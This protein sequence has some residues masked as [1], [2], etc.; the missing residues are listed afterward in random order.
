MRGDLG[1]L[2]WSVKVKSSSI[3]GCVAFTV[4]EVPQRVVLESMV[5][6]VVC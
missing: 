2:D 1:S 6:V 3:S 4:F 5:V